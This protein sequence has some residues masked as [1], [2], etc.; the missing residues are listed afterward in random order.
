MVFKPYSQQTPV[1]NITCH[2]INKWSP[3]AQ[4]ELVNLFSAVP[5]VSLVFFSGRAVI[6]S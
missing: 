1:M 5:L 3:M 2:V 4:A 6:A